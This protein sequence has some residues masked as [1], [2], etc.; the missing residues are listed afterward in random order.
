MTE[1]EHPTLRPLADHERV[2]AAAHRCVQPVGTPAEEPGGKPSEAPRGETSGTKGEKPGAGAATGPDVES[3]ER[4]ELLA[5]LSLLR[6]LR[7]HLDELELVLIE[8]ARE[9]RVSWS[10]ISSAL[11]L[12]SRQAAEQ[13]WLRLAGAGSRNA[14]HTRAARKRQR[15]IDESF[16]G[17][18]ASLRAAARAACR[19]LRADPD[20]DGRHPRAALARRTLEMA[21][22]ALPSALFALVEQAVADLEQIPAQQRAAAGEDALRRLRRAVAATLPDF[23]G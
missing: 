4:A 22:E 9:R 8:G 1:I 20:W 2:L 3:A 10:E 11:G 19:Q 7:S 5:A 13:R 23:D 15:I 18:I 14:A 6:G 17:R 16:G 21:G 12:A